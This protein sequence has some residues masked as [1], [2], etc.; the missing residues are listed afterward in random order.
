MKDEKAHTA[1]LSLSIQF[2]MLCTLQLFCMQQMGFYNFFR[3]FIGSTRKEPWAHNGTCLASRQNGMR[4]I[5]PT[6]LYHFRDALYVTLYP[7]F[8]YSGINIGKTIFCVPLTQNSRN[9]NVI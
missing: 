8:L 1:Q 3:I 2:H 5:C 6:D 9:P 7:Y 4:D